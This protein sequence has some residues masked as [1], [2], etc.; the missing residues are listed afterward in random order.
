MNENNFVIKK[1]QTNKQTNTEKI[2]YS[3]IKF[4]FNSQ[5]DRQ[6]LHITK[7]EICWERVEF[8]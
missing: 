3:L 2:D 1:Q 4:S 7:E 8:C 5:N 6:S